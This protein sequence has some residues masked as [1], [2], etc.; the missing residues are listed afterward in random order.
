MMNNK[1]A[2]VILQLDKIFI[3]LQADLVFQI[4]PYLFSRVEFGA[5]RRQEKED[6]IVRDLEPF[7][8]MESPVI[9]NDDF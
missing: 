4:P 5:V 8:F 9:Q 7:S 2:E 1:V 6:D 3:N